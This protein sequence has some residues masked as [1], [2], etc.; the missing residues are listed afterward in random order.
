MLIF[1][2]LIICAILLEFFLVPQYVRAMWPK[3]TKKSLHIKIITASLYLVVALMSMI[4]ANNTEIFAK[5]M[6]GGLLMSWIGDYFLHVSPKTWC[7]LI[8][9]TSFF[10]GHL[11]YISAYCTVSRIH[12]PDL[13]AFF[14]AEII[15]V[16]IVFALTLITELKL[17]LK[18]DKHTA[19]PT[20]LYGIILST[21]AVKAVSLGIMLCMSGNVKGGVVLILGGINFFLSDASLAIIYFTPHKSYNLKKFNMATYYTAQVLL[22]MSILFIK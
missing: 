1:K 5:L 21:M 14:P 6:F 10:C 16:I 15:A 11:F 8:G 4:V 18:F 7:F 17:S 2:I 3:K 19:V 22:A 20:V 9:I 12:F 13:P